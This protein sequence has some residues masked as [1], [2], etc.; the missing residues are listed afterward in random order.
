VRVPLGSAASPC[1]YV[2]GTPG[3]TDCSNNL[4]TND[5][6]VIFYAEDIVYPGDST[7]P[8]SFSCFDNCPNATAA[9][10]DTANP[11]LPF[12][13]STPHTYTFDANAM[14]LKYN[15]YAAVQTAPINGQNWGIMSGALFDPNTPNL[16]TILACDWDPNQICGW[17][18]WS[19]LDVFYTWET[20]LNN[21]NQFTGLK[22]SNGNFLRFEAPLSVK[23]VHRETGSP[24]DGAT[25]MLDYSGFGNLWGIPGKC[26]DMDS[27]QEVDCSTGGP[28]SPVRWVPAFTIPEAQASG[29][30]TTV[31]LDAA[32]KYFVK[33]LEKEQRMKAE[34]VSA[35]DSL[36][37]TS[38]TLPDLSTWTDPNI[39]T[40]PAVTDPPAVIGGIVQ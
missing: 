3:Y 17:K 25:F 6:P 20:G 13:Q 4:P 29:D 15:E 24:Y 10:I 1:T 40:E 8:A 18:A 39:G 14:L 26:V 27:G 9:G 38:Y 23:Y 22:D 33:P 35:C 37:P 16:N 2:P 12:N 34:A 11:F 21:W 31:E 30:L 5:T 36:T 32:T 19:A 7:V 28:G